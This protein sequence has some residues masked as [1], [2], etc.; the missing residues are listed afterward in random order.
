MAKR[1]PGTPHLS[2]KPEAYE[3]FIARSRKFVESKGL[4]WDLPVNGDGSVDEK[5]DWDLRVLAGS[6]ARVASR[7]N[8][9][10]VEESIQDC[11]IA[12]GWPAAL[13][14]TSLVLNFEV[15]EF[16]KSVIA[17]RCKEGILPRSVRNEA[18]VYRRFF[19]ATTKAPWELSTEDFDR[20]TD[21]FIDTKAWVILSALAKLMNE[22]M[23]SLHVPLEP[24]S[25]TELATLLGTVLDERSNANKLP[26]PA[27]LHELTRIV[28]NESPVSHNDRLRFSV[29][30]LLLFTGLRLNEILML[31]LDCLRWETHIDVVTGLPAG[32]VG[33]ISRTLQ[34]RY[35][36][37]KRQKG[38]PDLLVEDHQWIPE[39]FHSIIA[40]A[41][42]IVRDATAP[43]REVLSRNLSDA[44]QFRTSA[45]RELSTADLLFITLMGNGGE[46]PDVIP[47]DAFIETLN[48]SG[49]YSFM[50]SVPEGRM[51]IFMR[52]GKAPDCAAMTVN[53][54]SLRHL[55]N[56]EFF[57]LNVPDTIITQ[58]FGRQTVAQSYEY[59]HR[60]LAERLSFVQL[61]PSAVKM[62]VPG[63]P[64]E[65]VAKMVVGGFA[66]NSHI[67]ESFKKIQVEHGD[68][69]AFEYLVT[70]SDGFHVTPYGFCTT[71]FALNPCA[72]H[73]KCFHECKQFVASGLKEHTVSL[74]QL[75]S[76]LVLMKKVASAKPANSIGRKNQIEHAERLIAGV[77]AAL[78]AN[79]GD[80]VF[81]NGC[82]HSE[83]VKDLFA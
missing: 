58:H 9:F 52:Y 5:V 54:H 41:V 70:N 74:E 39:K 56:T 68:D 27:A 49:V 83:H 55:M 60:S 79:P 75:R 51:N 71:S 29:I 20:I 76:R 43:L 14:P 72:R 64:Q 65:V 21:L 62:I 38:R 25:R 34:L 48:E 63:T 33:G 61:P 16:I 82:D 37:L 81:K 47:E 11:A 32:D 59:D 69:A 80:V 26:D 6:H 53:P 40:E 35:F 2:Q 1:G 73:L 23:L 7:T 12:A 17:Q 24:A 67:A 30:R 15:Q 28:F 18:L 45:G 13:L 46:L 44:R 66:A 42:E 10:A 31:P 3:V 77:D 4:S 22:K 36:G 50:G 57:R 8:G 19:S 78:K